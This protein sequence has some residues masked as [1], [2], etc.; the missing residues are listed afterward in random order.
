MKKIIIASMVTLLGIG[1]ASADY[2]GESDGY[3]ANNIEQDFSTMP[4]T[5]AGKKS[6]EVE[7]TLPPG[8]ETDDRSR[9]KL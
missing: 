8:L 3:L 5:A 4:A 1:T 9:P 7:V 6:M 2:Q